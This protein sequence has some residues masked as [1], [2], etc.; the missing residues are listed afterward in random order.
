MPVADVVTDLTG[1]DEQGE[2]ST[3]AVADG[4]Q[5]GV[6]AALRPTDQASTPLFFTPILV[7]IRCAFR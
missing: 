3:L 1:G 7:A 5:L 2:R 6:H 4:V